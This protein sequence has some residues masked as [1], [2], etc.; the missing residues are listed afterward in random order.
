M[1]QICNDF[2]CSIKKW[3]KFGQ[4]R[5]FWLILRGF[6]FTLSG[7]LWVT[8]QDLAIWKNLLRNVFVVSFFSIAYVVVKLK[9]F[10]CFRIDSASMKW[11]LFGFFLGSYSPKYCFNFLQFCPEVVSNKIQSVWKILQNFAFWLKLDAPKVY[12][13]G[14]IWDPIYRQKTKRIALRSIR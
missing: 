9:T 5:I 8:S 12:S 11:S 10:R 7:T 1:Y 4:K 13:L 6:L 14:S 2:Y 3:M